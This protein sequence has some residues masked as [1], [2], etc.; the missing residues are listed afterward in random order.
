M[1]VRICAQTRTG[2]LSKETLMIFTIVISTIDRIISP[3]AC[4]GIY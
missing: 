1:P 4:K 3:P 2:R